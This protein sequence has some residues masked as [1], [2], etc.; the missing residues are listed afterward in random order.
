MARRFLTLVFGMFIDSIRSDDWPHIVAIQAQVYTEFEPERL[1]VLQQKWQLSPETCFVVRNELGQALAYLL[2]HPWQGDSPPHLDQTLSTE[3]VKG[4]CLYLH[5][6][7]VSPTLK[8]QGAG[9]ALFAALLNAADEFS[10]MQLIA[11]QNAS[12]YWQK[13]QFIR[14]KSAPTCYGS[15]A[16]LMERVLNH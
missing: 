10:K 15:G 3:L 12:S 11:V 4:D 6:L 8:G 9:K 2:S 14:L 7:A 5:D 13:H 16:Q 1:C